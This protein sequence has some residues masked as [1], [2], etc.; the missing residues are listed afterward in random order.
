MEPHPSGTATCSFSDDGESFKRDLLVYTNTSKVNETEKE[1]KENKEEKKKTEEKEK[2]KKEEE[3]DTEEEEK[4]TEEEEEDTEEEEEDT[5]EEEE[6][7][8]EETEEET[9]EEKK[10]KNKKEKVKPALANKTGTPKIDN[11]DNISLKIKEK[12]F[13]TPRKNQSPWDNRGKHSYE[14]R[15][16]KDNEYEN[17]GEDD[18]MMDELEG[19][20]YYKDGSPPPFFHENTESTRMNIKNLNLNK[21]MKKKYSSPEFDAEER[22]YVDSDDENIILMSDFRLGDKNNKRDNDVGNGSMDDS[23]ANV[24]RIHKLDYK[25]VEYKIDRLYFDINDKYSSA[26]DI[27]ASYLKGHK[28]L[29]MESK[30]YCEKQLNIFM[31]P[32][33]LF[34]TAATV[35]TSFLTHNYAWGVIFISALN[36]V[37]AFLLA[38]VNYLKLDAASEAHKISSHQYDKLQSTVEFTSGSILLFSNSDI[39]QLE[40]ELEQ[41]KDNEQVR[42]ELKKQ[43]IH[44]KGEFEKTMKK[45]MNE[46][47]NKIA[48]IKETNQFII[49]R[50]VRLRYPII[51][52][53][54][55]FS[56]I[57][58]IDDLR[59]RTITDLTTVK[60]EIRHF[61]QL[62]QAY[63]TS[64]LKCDASP[65]HKQQSKLQTIAK[66]VIKLFEKKRNLVNEIILLKSAFSIIDQM[67]HKEIKDAEIKRA[68]TFWVSK[69]TQKSNPENMNEFIRKLMDPFSDVIIQNDDAHY[70]DDYYKLYN[71]E[72]NVPTPQKKKGFMNL[73]ALSF[74]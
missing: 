46:V 37:I 15:N 73:G 62:K 27:L 30:F 13:T 71:M 74:N 56:V 72:K 33:I 55:I 5:E 49:P 51:Y 23:T 29:Y 52:N 11:I 59:K 38:V 7:E 22:S 19:G 57:K 3:E 58:R 67:F 50:I 28:I 6:E 43:I 48:E 64:F 17:Y 24:G 25:D 32:A 41:T 68:S 39:Q 26:L 4:D 18:N 16:Y 66:I 53:T 35:L 31:M 21:T 10:E 45:K 44:K 54:N 14:E 70:Y 36:G 12:I 42:A 69:K 40:Y 47:E 1:Q 61:T 60:N 63:E 34:S 20:F 9:K 8:E 65:T 2:E